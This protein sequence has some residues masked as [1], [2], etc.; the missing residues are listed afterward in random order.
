MTRPFKFEVG[1]Y[2]HIYNRGFEKSSIFRDRKD[3]ERFLKLLFL[4]NGTKPVNLREIPK[5]LTFGNEV[6]ELV[7]GK[8]IV[9]VAT[10]CLMGNHF[11]MLAREIQ[12]RGVSTFM[13]KIM[14]A[15]TMYF[16]T[17]YER[18]GSLFQGTFKARHLDDDVYLKYAFSYIHL[19]PVEHV[20]PKWKEEGIGNMKRVQ[21]YLDTYH[22]FSL[23]D[24][25]NKT[26]QETAIIKRDSLPQ[27]FHTSKDLME[28]MNSWLMFQPYTKV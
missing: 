16:N 3:K 21:D 2:Y 20:E 17:K 18:T 27:Y 12:P 23:P 19:N 9:E 10:Y 14:T 25:L 6:F 1:E 24:Y 5:G 22:Y 8:P 13:Q 11:H 28:E 15:H 4:C 7:R 26:R